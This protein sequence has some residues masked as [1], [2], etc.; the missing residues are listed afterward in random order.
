MCVDSW[1]KKK[2]GHN[3]SSKRRFDKQHC[4]ILGVC[5]LK[6]MLSS[7]AFINATLNAKEVFL[8]R[9]G[10]NGVKEMYTITFSRKCTPLTK[11]PVKYRKT[12]KLICIYFSDCEITRKK[13][14]RPRLLRVPSALFWIQV[15]NCFLE[16]LFRRNHFP[17]K[18]WK[19]TLS[20]TRIIRE[21][22]EA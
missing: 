10:W 14:S 13:T 19:K 16:T 9:K 6:H 5:L 15:K 20:T 3:M 8:Q 2:K 1:E 18:C 22:K 11:I 7:E 21:G 4:L 12:P 17:L